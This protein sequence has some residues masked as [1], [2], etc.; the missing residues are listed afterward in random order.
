MES[1]FRKGIPRIGEL[2]PMRCL[3]LNKLVSLRH[4]FWRPDR[5]ASKVDRDVQYSTHSA[6]ARVIRFLM[7]QFKIGDRIRVVKLDIDHECRKGKISGVEPSEELD[8]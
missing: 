2:S 4:V 3:Q 1:S 6:F 5:A 8:R 7:T